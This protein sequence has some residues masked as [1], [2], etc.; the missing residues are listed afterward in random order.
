MDGS[1]WKYTSWQKREPNNGNA[2]AGYAGNTGI[3]GAMGV[4]NMAQQIQYA[5]QSGGGL[6]NKEQSVLLR[7]GKYGGKGK[8]NDANHASYLTSGFVCQYS[9][10]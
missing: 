8:W 4:I 10:K 3:A 5:I 2:Y 1:E 6:E 9:N 7:G